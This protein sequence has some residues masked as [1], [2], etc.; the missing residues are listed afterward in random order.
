MSRNLIQTI[1]LK[2]LWVFVTFFCVLL[3]GTTALYLSFQEIGF[4]HAKPDLVHNLIWRSVFYIHVT[5][6]MIPLLIGPFQFIQSFRK[7]YSK[8]HRKLGETYVF[9][10]LIVGGPSGF[11]MA[12]FA[13]GGFWAQAGFFILSL[14]WLGTTYWA[15]RTAVQKDFKAHQKWMLRSF[16]LTFSAV[17]L[18]LWVPFLS[19]IILTDHQFTVVIT[20]WINWIPNIIIVEI[21]LKYF[22]KEL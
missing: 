7:K 18:R 19:Y 6:S 2:S 21:L 3:F 1:F 22:S 12:F 14:L 16:A 15:Y 20:A 4:L 9:C 5:G 11:Y 10:I 13:N 17:T 8:A